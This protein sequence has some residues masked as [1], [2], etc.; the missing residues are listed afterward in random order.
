MTEG[1]SFRYAFAF[2]LIGLSG[3]IFGS[4]AGIAGTP[5][6]WL[7]AAFLSVGAN[8]AF[9]QQFTVLRKQHGH[10]GWSRKLLLLPYFMMLDGTWH[11]LRKTSSEAPFVEL[12]EGIFIGRRLLRTE[13]PRVTT[14]VDLTSEFDEHVPR[15]ASLLAFPI[16]DGA[17]AEPSTLRR[18]AREIA[19]SARPIYIQ[20]AQGHGRTSM[21][22][23]AVLIEI[24]AAQDVATALDMIGAVRPDAKP[25]AAQLEALNAA[26]P[27]RR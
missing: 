9:P 5:L 25:N 26:F 13:Y 23:A 3:I 4:A 11:I 22:A 24:G 14:L 10:L 20:C 15:G 7:G 1:R 18:M 21:V 27:E 17:P 8:Y 12:I 16:L 19:A 6:I 2:A